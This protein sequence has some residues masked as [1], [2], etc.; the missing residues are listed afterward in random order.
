MSFGFGVSDFITIGGLFMKLCQDYASAPAEGRELADDLRLLQDCIA[1]AGESSAQ[2]GP[3]DNELLKSHLQ[4]VYKLLKD[5]DEIHDRFSGLTDS[6]PKVWDRLRFPKLKIQAMQKRVHVQISALNLFVVAQ[7][8]G[9]IGRIE[10]YL[11]DMARARPGLISIGDDE[12]WNNMLP[13]FQ[14][15]GIGRESAD[16]CRTLIEEHLV[17]LSEVEVAES[18]IEEIYQDAIV[19]EDAVDIEII[20]GPPT[21]EHHFSCICPGALL[22][23]EGSLDGIKESKSVFYR[24]FGGSKFELSCR[25]CNFLG[26]QDEPLKSRDGRIFTPL[27]FC[28]RKEPLGE[29]SIEYYT[30]VHE[31][32]RDLLDGIYY[33]TL[34]FWKCHIA[35]KL[36]TKHD[37]GQY[38]CV[39][40]P[41]ERAF[42]TLY[43]R[44]S[45]ID[46]IR[47]HHVQ[48]PPSKELRRKFSV[49]VD[50]Q[51]ALFKGEE[52]RCLGRKFDILLPRALGRTDIIRAEQ[53]KREA[54]VKREAEEKK[55]AERLREEQEMIYRAVQLAGK[56]KQTVKTETETETPEDTQ[57]HHEAETQ[58]GTLPSRER[59]PHPPPTT[60]KSK[61]NRAVRFSIKNESPALPSTSTKT[62]DCL[63]DEEIAREL[64]AKFY[65]EEVRTRS[66][67]GGKTAARASK[68]TDATLLPKPL[69]LK[70]HIE[71]P[72]LSSKKNGST[73]VDISHGESAAVMSGARNSSVELAKLKGSE[74]SILETPP[75]SGSNDSV[76]LLT[77][78]KPTP[79]K[80]EINGSAVV[81]IKSQLP[82]DLKIKRNYSLPT[83]LS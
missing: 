36:P 72:E 32:K 55:A 53:A 68:T 30:D 39:F 49:Y 59:S 64:Q 66:R 63:G 60:G 35:A 29:T 46:H 67:A 14:Q 23:Q 52:Q 77:P 8:Q 16:R 61:D 24:H 79:P 4:T 41:P 74:Y 54:E 75:K 50:E 73:E 43:D 27:L 40:C 9:S 17:A 28:S 37:T 1:K 58:Q 5:I 7:S 65:R 18:R 2:Y 57:E 76:T 3:E 31:N 56:R 13:E 11:K 80:T 15:L 51:P 33:H 38:E 21:D 44:K 71:V 12:N 69:K 47:R 83:R 19:P 48:V 81:G 82:D 10:E 6:Q 20:T 26:F 34:F 62:A 22:L 70:S 25:H 45:L 78:P 42:G